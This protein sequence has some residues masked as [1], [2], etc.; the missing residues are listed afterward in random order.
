MIHSSLSMSPKELVC[1]SVRLIIIGIMLLGFVCR[2]VRMLPMLMIL[3]DTVYLTA[4]PGTLLI[5]PSIYAL[6]YAL[7]PTTETLQPSNV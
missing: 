4:V 2:S 7:Y 1:P 6:L 5:N 3:V